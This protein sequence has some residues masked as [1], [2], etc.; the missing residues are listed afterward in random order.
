MTLPD[1]NNLPR[2]DQLVPGREAPHAR[3]FEDRLIG[4]CMVVPADIDRAIAHGLT[5]GHF[6]H[7]DN[8]WVVDAIF[9]VHESSGGHVEI[10]TVADHLRRNGRLDQVGGTPRLLQLIEY[11]DETSRVDLFCLTII[12]R[13]RERQALAIQQHSIARLYHPDGATTDELLEELEQQ[14]FE[15]THGA[16]PSSYAAAGQVAVASL[17]D[18][19]D[20]LRR[21]ESLMG[22]TT[23]FHDLD[24][25]TTG[26]HDGNLFVIAARPGQGKSSL[27]C[28]S[29]LNATKPPQN[30]AELPEAAYLHSLEMPREEV[31]LNLVCSLAE[32]EFQ[33]LRKNQLTQGD[34]GK[35]FTACTELL[36]R[37][38][39]IDD[40]PSI[41][42]AEVRANVRKLK[43]EIS[44]GR[45]KAKALHLVAVDYLQL[46]RG[47]QGQGREREIASLSLGLKNLAKHEKVCVIAAAQLN[48]DVEKRGGGGGKGEGGSKKG[49]RPELTDLRESGAIEMDSDIVAFIYREK[50]YDSEASDEAEII[51]RKNR[52]GPTLTVRL[53]FDGP[54]KT[55][56]PRARGYEEF[57]NFGEPGMRP[58]PPDQEEYFWQT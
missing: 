27:L 36:K 13:Y 57:D 31:A 51:I 11:P 15:V 25:A 24:Q 48:R 54:H 29:L 21:G 1:P 6:A 28:S 56:K 39:F 37:Q 47:E 32:V 43:R 20:R 19:A 33:K 34:W 2:P 45:I 49:K 52:N 41:T 46:M 26:Y 38:I 42:V 22:V 44:L 23:G 55:F 35:L 12:D 53:V 17:T 30:E 8:R 16:K 10:I 14:L 50:Y 9:R 58:D 40:K 5:P 3:D 18:M 7:S 4:Q